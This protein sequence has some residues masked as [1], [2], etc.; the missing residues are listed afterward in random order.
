MI[1]T[2]QE[3]RAGR[4]SVGEK[5]DV[6]YYAEPTIVQALRGLAADLEDDSSLVLIGLWNVESSRFPEGMLQV[7]LSEID[8]DE[9]RTRASSTTNEEGND[10]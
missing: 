8:Q 3:L 5:C 6:R 4:T 2:E 10:A 9:D 7:A 1:D